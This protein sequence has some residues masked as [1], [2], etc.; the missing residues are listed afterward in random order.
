MVSGSLDCVRR[1]YTLRIWR[2]YDAGVLSGTQS[3]AQEKGVYI[4]ECLLEKAY[5]E[6]DEQ[7][8]TVDSRV[9]AYL[10]VRTLHTYIQLSTRLPK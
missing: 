1:G 2:E 6:G 5:I 9:N 3:G 4:I 7:N 10:G 8:D